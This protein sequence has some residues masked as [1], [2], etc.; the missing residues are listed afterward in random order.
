MDIEKIKEIKERAR[1]ELPAMIAKY[2]GV[3]ELTDP[4]ITEY[5]RHVAHDPRE[6]HC[7]W[8][9]L[10]VWKFL[11]L[12]GRYAW[13]VD[14]VQ[15]FFRLYEGLEFS[16]LRGRCRY[17]LTPVQCFQFA[18]IFGFMREDVTRLV[19]QAILLVPRKFGKTTS[20]AALNVEELLFGDANAQAYIAANSQMQSGICFKEAK[21]LVQQLDPSGQRFRT[22]AN[23]ITWRSN[24]FGKESMCVR[25][26]AGAK[27]K[28]GLNASLV[29]FDEYAAA[30]YVKDH[31]DGAELLNV[32]TSSFGV[33]KEPLTVIITT[34]SRVNGGPFEMM[35]NEAKEG[36]LAMYNG[37]D[38]GSDMVFASLFQPDPWEME[39]E[40]YGE[41][42]IWR[43]CNPH[44]GVTIRP[45]FYRLE[46][47]LARNN[48][49][50][51]K[52]FLCKYLNVFQSDKVRDWI[53]AS[54]I[55]ALQGDRRIDEID[56][57][58][59]QW[60]CLTGMD[61]SRGDDLCGMAYLC[62]NAREKRFF[63]DCD[64]WIVRNSLENH[65]NGTLY[66]Q[67]A[68]QGWLH[69]CEGDVIPEQVITDRVAELAKHVRLARFGYDPYDARAF[70]NYLEAWLRTQKADP[71]K[72]VRPVKQTWGQFNSA[73]QSF[74]RL[75][76]RGAVEFS[77]SPLIPWCFGN[78]VLEEDKMENVK[79]VKR[80]ANGKIDI[81]IGLLEGVI[82]LDEMM[83][84]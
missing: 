66:R 70:V 46:W 34:A 4:R 79:P 83:A 49:E 43:K 75:V 60:V 9:V 64:A 2:V 39:D 62:Y 6:E 3:L 61:F 47:E 31:S 13:N 35:L 78:A 24:E 45:D 12:L 77:P 1:G 38:E 48:L 28:D 22:T 18:N 7:V 50:K 23:E 76:K 65:A 55:A 72:M 33:R 19:R 74:E 27:T 37:T 14:R 16:G 40:F 42:Y 25:L 30:R 15:R 59:E 21:A 67:W 81:V 80:T 44:I 29:V 84:K 10:A 82:L 51:R 57:S 58:R 11:H 8:E 41:E 73:V 52:E 54:E 63:A 20:A 17:R 5:C 36:L 53:S 71:G 69:V 56:C 32:L 26:S 68:E